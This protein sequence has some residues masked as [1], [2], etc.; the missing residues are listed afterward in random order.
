MKRSIAVLLCL[1][2]ALASHSALAANYHVYK[3]FE[4]I[5]HSNQPKRCGHHRC[6]CAPIGFER[7]AAE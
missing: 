6:I 5:S 1:F 2:L 3:K 7:Q 4:A